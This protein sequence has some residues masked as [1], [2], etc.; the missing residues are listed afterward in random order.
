MMLQ[1]IVQFIGSIQFTRFKEPSFSQLFLMKLKNTISSY[2][3]NVW[4]IKINNCSNGSKLI[5]T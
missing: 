2:I 4:R 1:I 3:G 5:E